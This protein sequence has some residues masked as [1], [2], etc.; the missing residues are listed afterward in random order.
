[1]LM[2]YRN[3]KLKT[4]FKPA[5]KAPDYSITSNDDQE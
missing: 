2:E 3:Q 1:M 4:V 5:L